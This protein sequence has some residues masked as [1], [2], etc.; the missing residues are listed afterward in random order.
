MHWQ[1]A[2]EESNLGL[3]YRTYLDTY[4]C[5]KIIRNVHGIAHKIYPTCLIPVRQEEVEG[6][7]DWE[8][9]EDMTW[10][11]EAKEISEQDW[12]ALSGYKSRLEKAKP[13]MT[14]TQFAN[15]EQKKIPSSGG[16]IF[17]AYWDLYKKVLEIKKEKS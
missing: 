11:D 14:L 8:P 1:K 16:I 5:Q 10:I 6:Y 13:M 3:A 4:G 7:D 2:V 12:E 15:P 17:R 9:H